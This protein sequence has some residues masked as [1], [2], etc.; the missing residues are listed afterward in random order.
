MY[1]DLEE[2]IISKP[3]ED[4]TFLDFCQGIPRQRYLKEMKDAP[5]EVVKERIG[6]VELAEMVFNALKECKEGYMRIRRQWPSL[7]EPHEG[8]TYVFAV[9]LPLHIDCPDEWYSTSN[10]EKIDWSGHTFV[11]RNS[12]YSFEFV[13]PEEI[14]SL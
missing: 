11:T 13:S 14:E 5:L 4:A 7:G 12:I 9:G 8:W 6:D 10:I 3:V 2:I 1:E